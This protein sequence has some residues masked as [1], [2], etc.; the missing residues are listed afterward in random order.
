M[1]YDA[2]RHW[3]AEY[4][5]SLQQQFVHTVNILKDMPSIECLLTKWR[6]LDAR[7]INSVDKLLSVKVDQTHRLDCSYDDAHTVLTIHSLSQVAIPT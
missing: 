6:C 4:S 7:M 2:G 5:E 1:Y 3:P